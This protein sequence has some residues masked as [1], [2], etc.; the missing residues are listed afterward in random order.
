M[1]LAQSRCNST[2]IHVYN[3]NNSKWSR[4]SS[5]G[6]VNVDVSVSRAASSDRD[7]QNQA[8]LHRDRRD[9]SPAAWKQPSKRHN[10]RANT[11]HNSV[12]RKGD[13][14]KEEKVWPTIVI[15]LNI[16]K[17]IAYCLCVCEQKERKKEK[18]VECNWSGACH[19]NGMVLHKFNN[20]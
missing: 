11:V 9:E 3:N 12:S 4:K 17:C 19:E 2:P 20:F 7:K 14:G 13:A 15:V 18:H 6:N 16:D 1:T 10:G 8:H 5:I